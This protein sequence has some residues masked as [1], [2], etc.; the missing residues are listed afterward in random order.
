MTNFLAFGSKIAREAVLVAL[1]VQRP[2]ERYLV[3]D[4]SGHPEYPRASRG[5]GGGG[6]LVPWGSPENASV[7]HQR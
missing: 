2:L 7:N 1:A 6:A 5:E 3:E 4:L